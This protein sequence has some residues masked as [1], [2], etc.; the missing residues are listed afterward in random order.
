MSNRLTDT[1]QFINDLDAGVF[2][3][4]VGRAL[5]E[6][7]GGVI[8]H[9]KAGKL[10]LTFDLKRLGNANKVLVKHKLAFTVPTSKGKI[11]EEETT[12]S[13]MHVNA[14]GRLTSLPENQH[15]F[16]DKRGQVAEPEKDSEGH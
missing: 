2:T 5:S 11:T 15:Q 6:I 13:D 7:A 14:G 12:D 1:A 3:E 9:D 8:D 4:K 16:F 10:T